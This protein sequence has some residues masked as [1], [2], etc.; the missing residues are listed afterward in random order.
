MLSKDNFTK[1][2]IVELRRMGKADPA[3]L[4]RTLFAFGLLEALLRTEMP[5]I[6]KGGTALLLLL[7][8]PMRLSTDIDIIVEPGTDVDKYI[9]EAGR[10]FPF[11]DCHEDVRKGRNNIE[12]RH[13]KFIYRSPS[14]GKDVNILLDILFDECPYSDLTIRPLT[15]DLLI[16]DLDAAK[17]IAAAVLN[18]EKIGLS[19]AYPFRNLPPE[20]AVTDDAEYGIVI[21]DTTEFSSYPVTLHLIPKNI[22]V[23]IGCKKGTSAQ[24]I[25]DAVQ[26][27]FA[28]HHLSAGRICKAASI[29]LKANEDG[30]L[31]FCDDFGIT[32]HT[33]P[34]EELMRIQ[35]DFAHSDF[36][37]QVTGA[38][39]ICERSAVMC[40]GG[41]MILRKTARDGVT[42]AAAE[43][44]VDID[45]ER[46]LL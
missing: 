35:G 20:L 12:R 24:K 43:I 21:A 26:A 4:E 11:L 36:A 32:L 18:N 17:A 9:Q 6:F 27:A 15:N 40:A 44:P 8:K 25:K 29:D 30:L 41:R 7:D 3:I 5:F 16:T 38:D 10:I 19:C 45:F 33:Y 37:E 46:K 22:A 42:V 31:R 39:N 14:T 34:A 28:D 2:H 1:E 13:Y 23:G